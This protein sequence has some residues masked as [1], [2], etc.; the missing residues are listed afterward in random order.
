MQRARHA[1]TACRAPFPA[2]RV[3][4]S[5][6][7]LA[8]CG[9]AIRPSPHQAVSSPGSVPVR[10]ASPYHRALDFGVRANVA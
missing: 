5:C 9:Q 8:M 7:Q 2:P 3:R 6:G 1:P 4:W 10:A